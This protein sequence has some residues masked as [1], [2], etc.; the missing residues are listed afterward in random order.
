MSQILFS[1]DSSENDISKFV[2]RRIEMSGRWITKEE[3]DRNVQ[4]AY[5]AAGMQRQKEYVPYI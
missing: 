4:V 5:D 2:A 3:K 1:D